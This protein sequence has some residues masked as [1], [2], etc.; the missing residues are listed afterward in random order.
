[1]AFT[2]NRVEEQETRTFIPEGEYEV[3]IEK[4]ELGSN[5]DNTNHCI[6]LQYR[7]RDDVEQQYKRFVV[8]ERLW[9][10]KETKQFNTDRL[11][12]LLSC[13]TSIEDGKVFNS[14]QEVLD[15]LKGAKLI[16]NVKV[17][18]DDYNDVDKNFVYFYKKSKHLPQSLD[19]VASTTN[20]KEVAKEEPVFVGI[21]EEELPF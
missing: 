20:T 9:Q 21:T 4:A 14:L 17:E 6:S 1:M 2:F 18:H 12:R 11:H 19:Q 3:F 5:K 15:T 13:A 7:L 16:I 8:F 10:N